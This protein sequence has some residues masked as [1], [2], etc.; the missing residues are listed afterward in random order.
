MQSF[1]GVPVVSGPRRYGNLYLTEKRGGRPFDEEDE[2]LIMTL[3]AFAAAAIENALLVTAER[4]LA[5][6]RERER[7]R[8]E[9]LARVI[10]AQEAERARV[11]RDLHDEIGQASPMS[12]WRPRCSSSPATTPPTT[13]SPRSSPWRDSTRPSGCRPRSRPS[14]TGWCRRR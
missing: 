4:E 11:A 5:A 14:P 6:A 13:G 10:A 3:A 7:L 2:R 8:E 9:M 12:A 1:L